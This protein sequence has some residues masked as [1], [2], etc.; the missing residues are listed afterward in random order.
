LT[1]PSIDWR[2][3]MSQRFSSRPLC[4]N[5][6]CPG[7]PAYPTRSGSSTGRACNTSYRNGPLSEPSCDSYPANAGGQQPSWEPECR[8]GGFLA[9][10]TSNR[11]SGGTC[12]TRFG[13][14]QPG[15]CQSDSFAFSNSESTGAIPTNGEGTLP[16][17]TPMTPSS[18]FT[19]GPM[20]PAAP[21]RPQ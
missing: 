12:G 6:A 14:V 2:A 4:T 11:F 19:P 9:I 3:W 15:V 21:V 13:P 5:V 18:E 1:L 10:L 7:C 17:P 20:P 16:P 8:R